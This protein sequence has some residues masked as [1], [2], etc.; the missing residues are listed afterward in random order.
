MGPVERMVRR[1]G[2]LGKHA[3]AS[4]ASLCG[5]YRRWSYQNIGLMVAIVRVEQGSGNVHT[6][7]FQTLEN[8]HRLIIKNHVQQ[9]NTLLC[10]DVRRCALDCDCS[11]QLQSGEGNLL[12]AWRFSRSRQKCALQS[13][14]RWFVLVRLRV[15]GERECERQEQGAP[16]CIAHQISLGVCDKRTLTAADADCATSGVAL[17]A[18]DASSGPLFHTTPNV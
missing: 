4:A 12:S 9:H 16:N 17:E 6:R 3:L 15:G 5:D 18:S 8:R 14:Y 11:R 7:A 13:D 2:T 10:G 1:R